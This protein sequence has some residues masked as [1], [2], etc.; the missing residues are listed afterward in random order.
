LDRPSEDGIA[1]KVEDGELHVRS[2]NAM[3]GTAVNAA[4]DE[5]LGSWF[6]TGDLVER[7]GDR[8]LFVGRRDDLINVGGNKVKPVRVEQVIQDVPGVRDVRVFARSSSLVGQMVACEYVCEPGFDPDAIK[9]AILKICL[10]RLEAHER[11]RFVQAVSAIGLSGAD[12]KIR[13]AL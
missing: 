12:K 8:Y 3:L 2:A 13:K 9:N 6:A 7:V 11:P 4:T 10:E 1:L 5:S